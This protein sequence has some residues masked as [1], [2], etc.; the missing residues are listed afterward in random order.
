MSFIRGSA[1]PGV[2]ATVNAAVIGAPAP[3]ESSDALFAVIYSPWGPVNVARSLAGLADLT[4]QFGGLHA[5]SHGV[6][7]LHNFF[8]QGGRIAQVVRVVGPA[9]AVATVTLVDR[10]GAPV[11]TLRVDARYPSSSVDVRVRVEAGTEPNTVRITARSLKLGAAAPLEIFDNFKLTFTQDELDAINAGQSRL[12]DVAGVNSRSSLIRL[13]DLASGTAA[14]NNLPALSAVLEGVVQETVLAGGSD[15]FAGITAATFIGTDDG[16]DRTG[17][18]VF[19]TED[20][21]TGQVA[22]PGVT[23]QAAHAALLAHAERFKRFALL[24]PA[25]GSDRDAVAAARALLGSSYGAIHWPWVLQ[26]DLEGTGTTKFYP[27]SG[28]VAGICARADFETGI[29]KTPANYVVLGAVG[30]EL[31]ANGSSQ[32]DDASHA[33]LN[34]R[35]VNVIKTIREQGVKVYGAR[36]LASFGR[37]TAIHQQRVL[38]RIY[39]D[40]LRSY[41]E[42]PFAV[43]DAE[44]RLFREVKSIGEQ[45]LS[46][47]YRGGALTSPTGDERDAYVVICDESNNPAA[48]LDQHQV[49]VS[50]GVHIVGM[51]EMVFVDI[52]SVPLATSLGVLRREQ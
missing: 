43:L 4:R 7:A 45:Y 17:L 36:C 3:A 18:Q 34:Q 40:L 1:Q 42:I 52:N 49:N 16:L 41:Q 39:Y 38:N 29:H 20:F 25:F 30:V 21:G 47:L 8:R 6:A 37:V 35:E 5:N 33:F 44:G 2:H 51:A 14:P 11:N 26:P 46:E 28:F 32:T 10:A 23:T 9:A 48:S 50:V 13:A 19:N 27:P 22:L 24:D 12:I 31:A 15:D